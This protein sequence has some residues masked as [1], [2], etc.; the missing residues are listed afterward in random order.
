ML[1]RGTIQLISWKPPRHLGLADRSLRNKIESGIKRRRVLWYSK[2]I[3]RGFTVAETQQNPAADPSLG[4]EPQAQV[5]GMACRSG[6][7]LERGVSLSDIREYLRDS[8]NTVWVDIQDPGPEEQS[9]LLEEF[10]FHPLTVED[11]S[12][13]PST[14][15][16]S[17][18]IPGYLFSGH[19]WGRRRADGRRRCSGQG[20][21]V[22]RPELPGDDPPRPGDRHR[23][24]DGS[25][26]Q[27]GGPLLQEG[28]GFLVYTVMDTIIDSYFPVIDAIED[29]VENWR[30]RHWAAHQPRASSGC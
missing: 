10:G 22:H 20:D 11:V 9:L 23:G 25:L 27:H 6:L 5:R 15:R 4:R 16:K 24:C 7:S 13:G 18:S 17:R 26:G 29:Q 19:L 2:A 30:R 14:S 21:A 1:P 3:W 12:A 28:V 8:A